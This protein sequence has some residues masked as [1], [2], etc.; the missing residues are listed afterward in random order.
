MA[1]RK[2][3]TIA[4]ALVALLLI[5]LGVAAYVVRPDVARLR[6]A[7]EGLH[8]P[9]HPEGL[10]D[11]ELD[12]YPIDM[13]PV[14]PHL[15]AGA[16]ADPPFDPDGVVW[17]DH[18][19][20]DPETGEKPR[21]YNPVTT[22]QY[23]LGKYEQYMH[24]EETTLAAFFTQADWLRDSMT[25][26]GRLEYEYSYGARDLEAPWISAMAQGEAISVL[27][28]A[29]RASGDESYLDAALLAYEPLRIPVA[30]GGAIVTDGGELW[31]EEYPGTPPSHVF[32]GHVFAAF[33]IRDLYLA[34]GEKEYGE[35]W[36]LAADT[37][38]AHLHEYEHDGW[39]RYDLSPGDLARAYYYELQLDQV[40][41][42]AALTGDAR[43]EEAAERWAAP[44]DRPTSWLLDR[45]IARVFDRGES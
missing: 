26:D 34:T 10:G 18:W 42:M 6:E 2:V 38:A 31:L 22:T 3:L 1:S 45:A 7:S 17:V 21:V 37:L 23:A 41:A 9:L 43:F 20:V 28:R 39:L 15:E 29:W 14:A 4:A 44:I 40:R 32:N 13:R 35:A 5:V 8:Q 25:A 16:G 12:H 36:L 19:Q 30:D 11:E 24:S 27:V 33:G